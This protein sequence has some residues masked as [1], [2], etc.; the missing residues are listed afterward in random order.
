MKQG[1][2]KVLLDEKLADWS[3]AYLAMWKALESFDPTADRWSEPADFGSRQERIQ[4]ADNAITRAGTHGVGQDQQQDIQAFRDQ[5]SRLAGGSS[6]G[7]E[8]DQFV[9]HVRRIGS[10]LADQSVTAANV[11]EH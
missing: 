11:A 3:A 1:P 4:A 2:R 6:Y 7:P 8:Q 5:L 10:S 9:Q